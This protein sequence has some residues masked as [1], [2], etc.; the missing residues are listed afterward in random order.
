MIL[1]PTHYGLTKRTTLEEH[2]GELALAVRRKSRFLIKDAHTFF[3]K[4]Q[5]IKKSTGTFP[6]LILQAPL[7]SKAR[8]WLTQQSITLIEEPLTKDQP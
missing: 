4:A 1:D 3:D 2:Q 6:I 5:V 7:C 8:L